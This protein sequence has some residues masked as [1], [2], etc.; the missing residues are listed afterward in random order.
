MQS[1]QIRKDKIEEELWV[2]LEEV[3]DPEI[4]VISIQDLGI[5]RNIERLDEKIIITITPTYSGCPAMDTICS[6]ISDALVKSGHKNFEIKT[7]LAPAWT[8][9]AITEKGKL[10]LKAF[11]IAPPRKRNATDQTI[12]CPLCQSTDTS[13]ISEFGST[14]CKSLQKCNHC[15]ESF[16]SFKPI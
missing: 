7:V 4:P 15:K 2:V 8:T 3:K 6:D 5:L 11:G 10:K 1:T 9:D 13:L 14:A 12:I 16:C